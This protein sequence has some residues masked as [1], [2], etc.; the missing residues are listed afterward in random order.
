[1]GWA[2]FVLR[3][4]DKLANGHEVPPLRDAAQRTLKPYRRRHVG[5][6]ISAKGNEAVSLC[7]VRAFGTSAKISSTVSVE[8]ILTRGCAPSQWTGSPARWTGTPAAQTTQGWPDSQASRCPAVEWL[9][10]SAVGG[11]RGDTQ[12]LRKALGYQGKIVVSFHCY[13]HDVV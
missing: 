13:N 10:P 2:D 4:G 5:E 6:R 7:N 9:G 3:C 8:W 11:P 12:I 1:M